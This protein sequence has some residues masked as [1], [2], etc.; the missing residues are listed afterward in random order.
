MSNYQV[1]ETD[2][3]TQ[4]LRQNF[5]GQQDKIIKKLHSFVYQQLSENPYFGKNIKKLRGYTPD[6]WRYRIGDVRFFYTI[7]EQKNE[8]VMITAATRADAY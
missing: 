6:T 3:F 1:F 8:V 2:R 5:K 7:D 4:D